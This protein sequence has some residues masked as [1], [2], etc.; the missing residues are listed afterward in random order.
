VAW[1]QGDLTRSEENRATSDLPIP[2]NSRID[3][4]GFLAM[5]VRFNPATYYQLYARVSGY[6]DSDYEDFSLVGA[7]AAALKRVIDFSQRN[8]IP[9]VF[10]NTPLTDEYL[11]AYR[12]NAETAFLQFMLQLSAT[13]SG[14]IFR[15]LGQIWPQRYDYFSDPSHLN[16]YGAYQVSNRIAQDPMIPWPQAEIEDVNDAEVSANP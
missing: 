8:E 15:D 16:R 7:Q 3:F 9:L 1:V 2:E 10:I 12:T 4:D 13:E 14:F 5:D 11:D 6:Y